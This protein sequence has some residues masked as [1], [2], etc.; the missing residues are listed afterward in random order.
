MTYAMGET[1]QIA[2]Y[3]RLA[4]DPGLAAMVG[5]AIYDLVPDAAPDLFVALGP[6]TANARSDVTG[7]GAIHQFTVSVVTRRGGYAPAKAA[8]A[9]VSDALA[10]RPMALPRGKLVS[11]RFVRARARR[12]EGEGS[13]RIDMWFRARLDEQTD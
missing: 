5:D 3:E 8:A 11:M 1:L 9:R 7:A 2:V 4:A 12:D 13:R 6:E 10:N